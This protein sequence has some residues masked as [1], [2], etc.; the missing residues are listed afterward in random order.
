[1]L[2]Q[3]VLVEECWKGRNPNFVTI[4]HAEISLQD[5]VR[6]APNSK[7]WFIRED[8][9]TTATPPGRDGLAKPKMG[10]LR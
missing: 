4:Q 3:S 2:W 9:N 6:G 7:V 5:E 8:S 1:M 10:V